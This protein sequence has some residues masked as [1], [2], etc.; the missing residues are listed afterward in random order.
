MRADL[1]T[2]RVTYRIGVRTANSFP[3]RHEHNLTLSI[4]LK[5][6]RTEGS[7]SSRLI[8]HQLYITGLAKN[9]KTNAISLRICKNTAHAVYI[10]IS[11][12]L[13]SIVT[14]GARIRCNLVGQKTLLRSKSSTSTELTL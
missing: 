2:W 4:F 13:R 7:F 6:L 10:T 11:L 1:L 8:D 3:C 5:R 12:S 9:K 14:Q